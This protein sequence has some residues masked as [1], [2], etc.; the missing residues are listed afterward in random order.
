LADKWPAKYN[1]AG[2]LTW[3]GRL[4]GRGL[5]Q[6]LFQRSRIYHGVWGTA[7]FQSIYEPC[8]GHWPSLMLMPEWY[9]VLLFLGFLT[10]LGASWTPLLWF[11]PLLLTGTSLTLIQAGYGGHRARFYSEPRSKLLRVARRI[12]VAG[13]HLVQPLARLVGRVQHGLGPWRW[14]SFVHVVPL[15]NVQ[16]LWSERWE[17]IESRLSQIKAILE[18]SSAVVVPGGD[19]DSWDFS[20]RGGLFGTVR[21]I[22]MV[23]EHGMGR[24]LCRFRSTP[25]SPTSALAILL[26]LIALAG[27]A[28]FDQAWIASGSLILIASVLGAL[29]YADCAIA[30]AHWRSAVGKY[31]RRDGHLHTV[32]VTADQKKSALIKHAS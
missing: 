13:L 11:G 29:I 5:V 30:M 31:L 25:K 7:P 19:F 6:T 32:S 1:G 20:V 24:Q 21:V 14:R 28:V 15:P 3:Q 8:L 23:E 2:H 18:Q 26:A 12:L 4:Y 16:S 17:A 10:A 27:L 22:A 9:F